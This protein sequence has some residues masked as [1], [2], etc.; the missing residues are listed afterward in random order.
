MGFPQQRFELVPSLCAWC[1]S[2]AQLM[3][4][5]NAAI[6]CP[7]CCDA[8]I[9]SSSIRAIIVQGVIPSFVSFPQNAMFV[10]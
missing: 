9:S 7:M 8:V 2:R 4:V 6:Q 1:V 10:R 3:N 5:G